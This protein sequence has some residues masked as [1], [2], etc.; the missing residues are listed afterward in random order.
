MQAYRSS[1]N[2]NNKAYKEYVKHIF[3]D[4]YLEILLVA[5]VILKKDL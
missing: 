1:K 4:N 2:N 3:L 5:L